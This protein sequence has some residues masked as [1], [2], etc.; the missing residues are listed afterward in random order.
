MNKLDI[1]FD[2]DGVLVDSESVITAAACEALNRFGIPAKFED[3]KP[4][5]GMGENRFLGGVAGKYGREFEL[6]MKV[7][8]YE[9]YGQ[10]VDEQLTVYPATK[11]VLSRLAAQGRG[12]ALASSADRIKVDHNLRVAGI[13]E[14]VFAA[15]LT[16]DDVAR[17]KPYP[18]IYLAAAAAAGF[19]P[20]ACIVVE[21]ALTGIQAG[22]DA[23]ARVIAITT[24]FDEAA[25]I[26][27]GADAVIDDIAQ[28]PD[29]IARIEG[30]A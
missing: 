15:V 4:F 11:S 9:I 2:M 6:P 20:S 28:L 5:T 14:S 21:D 26:E 10:V 1:L 7:L 13:D 23:G 24:A 25:L 27:A 17:K 18:D 8:C 30:S 3:F 16:G 29:A 22:K 19:D 12:L